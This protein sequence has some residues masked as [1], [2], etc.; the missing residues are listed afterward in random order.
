M[1]KFFSVVVLLGMLVFS[2]TPVMAQKPVLKVGGDAAFAPFEFVDEKNQV[3][4]FDIDLVK[5]IGEIIGYEVQYLNMAWD[6]LIPSLINK[7]IDIIAS[8]MSITPARQEQVN[9]S[10]PYFTSVLTI[11]VHKNNNSIKTLDDLA[12]KKVVVQIN[13]TGDFACD[14][15]PGVKVYRY[16]TAPEALQ[17][18]ALGVCDAAVI[19]LPVAEAYFAANPNAPLKHVG[20]VSEDDFFGLA[21]RKEDTE[22]LAKVNA[23]LAEIKANGTYDQIFAKWFMGE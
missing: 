14:D 7:N 9:F 17:N 18:V 4:G 21:I 8:G 2:V 12:N 11:V 3:V 15:I 22:L 10:D 1:K 16:N 13:T 19:D 5:A 23:A 6:G 20:K